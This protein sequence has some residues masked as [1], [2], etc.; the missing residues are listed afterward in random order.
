MTEP[1]ATSRPARHRRNWL[2][3][4]SAAA[5][6]IVVYVGF[7][8]AQVIVTS[9]RDDATSAQSAPAQ[10]IIV[11]GAA[12]YNGRPSPVLKARLDH[13][14]QL[15]RWKLAPILVVTGGRQ[16]GDTYTEATTGYMYLRDRGVPDAAIRKEV[17]GGS[18]WESLKAASRF[19][20]AESITKVILVSDDYHSKRLMEIAGEVGLSA[21]VSPS[22]EPM[23]S[24]TRFRFSVRETIAVSIGRLTGFHA[25]DRR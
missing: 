24:T 22:R 23:T 19:L 13:A 3:W 11:L 4:I 20:H 15:Y 16:P 6:L 14:L 21:R 9:H 18:T 17:Q 8:F 25:L 10:A 12:Q 5:V 7:T 2:R 1:V